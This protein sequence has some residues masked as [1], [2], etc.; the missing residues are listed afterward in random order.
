MD[1]ERS[2]RSGAAG[3]A[4][5]VC[6]GEKYG[7]SVSPAGR[8]VPG[9]SVGGGGGGLLA[10]KMVG[11]SACGVSA[12]D[13]GDGVDRRRVCAAMAASCLLWSCQI[14]MCD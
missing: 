7:V 3:N 2:V 12:G 6:G 14:S 11:F 5:K 8:G 4:C 9:D 10:N 1:A 13:E